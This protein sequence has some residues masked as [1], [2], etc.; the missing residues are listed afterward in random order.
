MG[1][2]RQVSRGRPHPHVKTSSGPSHASAAVRGV[3]VKLIGAVLI[4]F[5]IVALII[6]GIS[7]TK[8]EKV[9]EIGP[10]QA[11]TETEKTIPLP[12]I[13]GIASVVG[14][15]VLVVADS[16]RRV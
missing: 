9:L 7:Y 2:Q 8:R 15:I 1:R 4:V 6:G 16:R 11:T 10:V 3:L 14:G 13:V 12:P 5:G